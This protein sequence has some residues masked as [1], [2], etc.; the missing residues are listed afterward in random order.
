MIILEQEVKQQTV[1]YITCIIML[2]A[3]SEMFALTQALNRLSVYVSTNYLG[4]FE[5]E[6]EKLP[7]N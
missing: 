2:W 6:Y 4:R 3:R 5:I 1:C 7:F